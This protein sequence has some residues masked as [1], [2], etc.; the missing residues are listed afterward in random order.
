MKLFWYLITFGTL[1]VLTFA[2][3]YFRDFNVQIWTKD[4]KFRDLSVLNLILFLKESESF[5][6]SR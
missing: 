3:F 5:Q 2:R 4:I 6:I 1:L